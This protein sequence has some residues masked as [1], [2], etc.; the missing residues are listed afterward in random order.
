MCTIIPCLHRCNRDTP[1]SRELCIC[2]FDCNALKLDYL[3][4][5]I[6]LYTSHDLDS[7]MLKYILKFSFATVV[8]LFSKSN[9]FFVKSDRLFYHCQAKYSYWSGI[10]Y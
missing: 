1:L 8:E 5:N 2:A 4:R 10:I 7:L 3:H 9:I 6:V